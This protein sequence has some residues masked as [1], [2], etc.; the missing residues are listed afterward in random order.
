MQLKVVSGE[1]S[2]DEVGPKAVKG[3]IFT[4]LVYFFLALLKMLLNSA[5]VSNCVAVL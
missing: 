2:C 1:T 3:L 4:A 5:T